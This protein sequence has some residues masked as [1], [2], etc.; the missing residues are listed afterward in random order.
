MLAGFYATVRPASRVR[1][2][3]PYT[4]CD[5]STPRWTT[6][7]WPMSSCCTCWALASCLDAWAALRPQTL[8]SMA[9]L[10]RS[11]SG[12]RFKMHPEMGCCAPLARG[13]LRVFST[14]NPAWGKAFTRIQVSGWVAG[15]AGA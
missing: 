7:R 15:A 5:G 10:L 8:P 9:G 13:K 6:L 11:S 2:F 14:L 3:E 12:G 4:C 1:R